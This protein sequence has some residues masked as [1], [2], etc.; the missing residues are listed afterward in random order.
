M[1][2]GAAISAFKDGD[3]KELRKLLSKHNVDPDFIVPC[4][5]AEGG[6]NEDWTALFEAV[7]AGDTK[8]AGLLL[9]H[10]ADVNAVTRL[11]GMKSVLHVA[12]ERVTPDAHKMV[13]ILIAAGAAVGAKDAEGW[14][15]C[16]RC[17]LVRKACNMKTMRLLLHD[18]AVHQPPYS[19]SRPP[20]SLH[21]PCTTGNVALLK[22]LVAVG[23]RA[24]EP[25][26][27][28]PGSLAFEAAWMPIHTACRYGRL[29]AAK[30]VLEQGLASASKPDKLGRT[31][32]HSLFE[33]EVGAMDA[34]Q[35]LAVFLIKKGAD[36]NAKDRGGWT[37]CTMT[38][39]GE[40]EQ[41]APL[42]KTIAKAAAAAASTS[43]RTSSSGAPH[44]IRAVSE[45]KGCSKK[46]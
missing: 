25:H 38:A 15:P 37:P 46:W 5:W 17:A 8:M 19:P 16:D 27:G 1:S 10:G 26:P 35:D 24:D 2:T 3:F 18:P 45:A 32:L 30:F 22:L 12:A 43:S 21:P 40:A 6:E 31:P 20:P 29:G 14:L 42:R 41:W 7:D 13:E 4:A 33:T 39:A 44:G 36:P 9:K 11:G 34:K 28:P 23:G